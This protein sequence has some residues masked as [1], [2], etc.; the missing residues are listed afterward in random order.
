M[1]RECHSEAQS[2]FC[3]WAVRIIGGSGILGLQIVF[4]IHRFNSA[5]CESRASV[6]RLFF[7]NNSQHPGCEQSPEPQRRSVQG[8]EQ[9]AD[10]AVLCRSASQ[11]LC[12][13]NSLGLTTHSL[14]QRG[15]SCALQ[16]WARL[17]QGLAGLRNG[18]MSSCFAWRKP[19]SVTLS[20][21]APQPPSRQ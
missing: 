15:L 8:P 17:S 14:S 18:S 11:A 10:Y 5:T 1:N 13:A 16:Q 9:L 6:S 2:C 7:S 20:R 19:A 3:D 21:T 12:L 4:R